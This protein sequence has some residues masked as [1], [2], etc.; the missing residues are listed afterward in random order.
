MGFHQEAWKLPARGKQP[1]WHV[2]QDLNIV[3]PCCSKRMKATASCNHPP[4]YLGHAT[5]GRDDVLPAIRQWVRLG[6]LLA[7][8]RPIVQ[9][10]VHCLR[11]CCM[12]VPAI[13]QCQHS[14]LHASV[15]TAGTAGQLSCQQQSSVR[16]ATAG[17]DS[18][19]ESTK[20]QLCAAIVGARLA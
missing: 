5:E 10:I 20:A 7:G 2:C 11:P 19:I 4:L 12:R 14:T 15:I 9:L 1:K 18:T 17:T 6:L 3:V 16:A 8:M 13:L